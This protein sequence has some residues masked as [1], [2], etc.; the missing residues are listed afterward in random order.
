MSAPGRR[1]GHEQQ[2]RG[3][4]EQQRDH[5][6]EPTQHVLVA[7][8]EQRG[9]KSNR[10]KVCPDDPALAVNGGLLDLRRPPQTYLEP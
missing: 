5:K 1:R 7:G 8:A 4:I 9:E 2:H 10:T 6:D 3:R